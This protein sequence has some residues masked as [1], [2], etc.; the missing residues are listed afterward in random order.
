[1]AKRIAF[2]G[3][4]GETYEAV[5]KDGTYPDDA[6]TISEASQQAG[7]LSLFEKSDVG[8]SW[9]LSG[10]CQIY[11]NGV[12]KRDLIF[13]VDLYSN[14]LNKAGSNRYTWKKVPLS[15]T[16]S[17]QTLTTGSGELTL[18]NLDSAQDSLPTFSGTVRV[19]IDGTPYH[20]RHA[21]ITSDA[22]VSGGNV[23]FGVTLSTF[24]DSGTPYFDIIVEQL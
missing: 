12:F 2:L 16:E 5:P 4:D 15:D 11:R 14:W 17:E 21:H 23:T 7:D 24:G 9:D 20:D 19:A 10:Q 6:I 22:Q 3:D 8:D 1:M 13:D 18:G